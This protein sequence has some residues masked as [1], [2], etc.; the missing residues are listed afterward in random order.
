MNYMNDSR[1]I[2][3]VESICSG[4]LSNVLSQPAIVHPE[5]LKTV[6][7]QQSIRHRHL[8]QECF[9]RGIKVLQAETQCEIVQRNLSLEVK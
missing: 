6:H 5:T 8:I 1:E 7:A 2:Q 9:T 4:K 3:D